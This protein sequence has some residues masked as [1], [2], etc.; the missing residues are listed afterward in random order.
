MRRY[1]PL[2]PVFIG[3]AIATGCSVQDVR[4]PS[5]NAPPAEDATVAVEADAV[6]A[7]STDAP[8]TD[9]PSTDTESF[10]VA[11]GAGADPESE[12][13]ASQAP[14]QAQPD[15][16]P[17]LYHRG[18]NRGS[19]AFSISQ[20]ARTTDDWRLV[21]GRWQQ[22]ID[23]LQ[24]VPEGSEAYEQAQAKV[25]EYQRNLQ[26]AQAKSQDLR[27]ET[28]TAQ[29]EKR[30]FRARIVARASGTPVVLVNF[31]GQDLYPMIVDTGASGTLITTQMANE[32]NVVPTGV[33][34]SQVADGRIVESTAGYVNSVDV[35]GA[36]VENLEISVAP[37]AMGIGL[38]GNNFFS[39]YN[40]TFEQDWVVFRER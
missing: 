10:P 29:G 19:S 21:A 32:L 28:V 26:V 18:V 23:L 36:K 14:V 35:A 15:E 31:N 13:A 9:A 34:Y 1:L 11:Q 33:I 38:L 24:S 12:T 20:T 7:S 4:S 25:A 6:E 17:A 39:R 22:A 2:A 37:P 27:V 3:L 16:G 30:T 5:G 8:S 40:V